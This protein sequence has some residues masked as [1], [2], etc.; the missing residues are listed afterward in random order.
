[1]K[2]EVLTAILVMGGSLI[3]QA[4]SDWQQKIKDELP[5][6][7]HRNWIVIVDSAYP[8]QTSPIETIETDT[9]QLAVVDYVLDAMK[10]SIHVRPIVH[11]DK[12]LEFLNEKE[13]PG[14]EQYRAALKQRFVGL[15]ADSL[16]H[17]ALIDQL[18][19]TGKSFHVL[20]LKTRMTIPY[21]S[22]FLQLDC[23]YWSAASEARLREEMRK[24]R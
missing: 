14:V 12:E 3:A 22:V 19:E 7:G 8:L 5:L 17:Q 13:A 16:L 2:L 20:A 15:P 1:M 9:D 23:K 21:S 11:T 18:S 6:M 24:A 4:Q 10:N